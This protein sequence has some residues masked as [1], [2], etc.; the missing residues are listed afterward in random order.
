MLKNVSF[1]ILI[2]F[3]AISCSTG[4][5]SKEKSAKQNPVDK[6]AD[7]VSFAEISSAEVDA[8]NKLVNAT[9]A[10]TEESIMALYRPREVAPEGNYTYEITKEQMSNGEVEVTLVEEGL[11]DDSQSG[12][13]TKMTL[14]K[15]GVGFTILEITESYKCY[16]G[17]GSDDW[18]PQRCN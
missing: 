12:Q 4:G 16:Q 11:M 8:L 13:Q 1:L 14:K 7:D 17:R 2:I 9:K 18:S 5:S 3:V 10:S 15:V 6:I